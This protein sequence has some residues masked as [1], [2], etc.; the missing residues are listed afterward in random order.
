[1]SKIT[2]NTTQAKQYKLEVSSNTF[3]IAILLSVATLSNSIIIIG[4]SL[5]LLNWRSEETYHKFPAL[6]YALMDVLMMVIYIP[7]LFFRNMGLS[8]NISVVL[9][10]VILLSITSYFWFLSIKKISI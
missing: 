3:R 2:R 4:Q 9:S 7:A 10:L 8:M 6:L 5:S 1:M